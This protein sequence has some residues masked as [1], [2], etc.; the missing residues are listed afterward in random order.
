[1]TDINTYYHIRKS[2]VKSDINT[3]KIINFDLC[4]YT[5][6]D[7]GYFFIVQLLQP[8]F[9]K[10][11]LNYNYYDLMQYCIKMNNITFGRRV[12]GIWNAVNNTQPRLKSCN[13]NLKCTSSVCP[14]NIV[15]IFTCCLSFSN[16]I[17]V[18]MRNQYK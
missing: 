5:T 3:L 14:S 9:V 6:D 17:I 1:M 8:K 2:D 11:P 18:C 10:Q 12:C 15:I 4:L 16:Y 7:T 13:L